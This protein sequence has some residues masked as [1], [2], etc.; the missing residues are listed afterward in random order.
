MEENSLATYRRKKSSGID[1]RPALDPL[2]NR[3][4]DLSST[5]MR[6]A[7]FYSSVTPVEYYTPPEKPEDVLIGDTK[8]VKKQPSAWLKACADSNNWSAYLVET[9]HSPSQKSTVIEGGVNKVK[10]FFEPRIFTNSKALFMSGKTNF[11]Y[12][13][14]CL[15]CFKNKVANQI[16]AKPKTLIIDVA[17]PQPMPPKPK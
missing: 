8:F 16:V 7:K 2:K 13:F 14:V 4:R 9:S 6:D 17:M 3:T 15:Y 10:Q 12:I 11:P 1:L 5:N